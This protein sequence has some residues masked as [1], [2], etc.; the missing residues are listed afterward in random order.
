MRLLLKDY[1]TVANA[2]SGLLAI[3]FYFIFGYFA[4]VSLV[5]LALAFDFFDGIAARGQKSQNDFGIQLDSLADSVSFAATP[6]LLLFWLYSGSGFPQSLPPGAG[7]LFLLA[8]GV[9]FLACTLIRL[10]KFNLQKE[11]G[12]YYGLPSPIAAVLALA[13]GW[14]HY[15]VALALFFILGMA[16]LSQFKLK[17]VF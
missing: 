16:M 7:L 6:P 2:A 9:F 8:G 3:A 1:L 5:L 13:L 4:A 12:V 15:Y 11:K 14:L 17:K 10:A